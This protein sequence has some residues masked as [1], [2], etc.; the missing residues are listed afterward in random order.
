MNDTE[1]RH[2]RAGSCSGKVAMGFKEAARAAKRMRRQFKAAIQSYRCRF[3][4]HWH[5]GE[6]VP[7]PKDRRR[8]Q[9]I[10]G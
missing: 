5:V 4:Q 9:E 3:C 10:P 2:H 7:N 1:Q 8:E 6:H